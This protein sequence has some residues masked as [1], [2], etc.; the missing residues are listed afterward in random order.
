MTGSDARVPET[1]IMGSQP[2]DIF[3]HRG[4]AKWVDVGLRPEWE[5]EC[6]PLRPAS[7]SVTATI[8]VTGTIT[9]HAQSSTS[10]CA[11]HIQQMRVAVLHG[12][13]TYPM[14]T[15]TISLYSP[16][17]DSLNAVLMIA[18]INFKVKHIIV[19]VSVVLVARRG[20]RGEWAGPR[21]GGVAGLAHRGVFVAVLIPRPS[22]CHREGALPKPTR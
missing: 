21:L 13:P 4:I 16:H 18:L 10:C 11:R 17:D 6:H 3:V 8:T 1:T 22:Y 12:V 2:G 7:G 5:R 14:P 15:L 9:I 20:L 19:A